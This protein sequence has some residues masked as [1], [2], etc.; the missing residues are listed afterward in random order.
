MVLIWPGLMQTISHDM[1][2]LKRPLVLALVTKQ[3]PLVSLSLPPV[4]WLST[5]DARSALVNF[6]LKQSSGYCFGTGFWS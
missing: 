6:G 5:Y 1:P 3:W 2:L 4:W